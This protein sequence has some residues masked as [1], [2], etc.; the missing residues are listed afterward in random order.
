MPYLFGDPSTQ[1]YG[2][3]LS[4]G[5]IVWMDDASSVRPN[6]APA[7]VDD[8]GLISIDP[9]WLLTEQSRAASSSK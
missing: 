3:A 2:A 4:R 9:R 1:T 6:P 5:Q 7:F 8:I